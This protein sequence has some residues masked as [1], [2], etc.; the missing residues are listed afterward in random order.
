MNEWRGEKN[1]FRVFV[2]SLRRK[3][4]VVPVT[5]YFRAITAFFLPCRLPITTDVKKKIDFTRS[6]CEQLLLP[7]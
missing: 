6:K 3:S 7:I 5:R 2:Q 4:D 1:W